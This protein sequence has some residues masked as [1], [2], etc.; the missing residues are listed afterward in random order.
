MVLFSVCSPHTRRR[1][2]NS[3]PARNLNRGTQG[4]NGVGKMA[5]LDGN[6]RNRP[7][8]YIIDALLAGVLLLA[9]YRL[10]YRAELPARLAES[11]AGFMIEAPILSPAGAAL[12]PGDLLVSIEDFPVGSYYQLE[13]ISNH[14][15]P[16]DT[17]QVEVRRSGALVTAPVIMHRGFP[18]S[19]VMISMA[20]AALYFFL[21]VFVLVRRRGSL[22]ARVF[23]GLMVTA[24]IMLT[25]SW[26]SLK[27]NPGWV[28]LMIQ[29]LDMAGNA[30][31]PA[32][33]LHF[34][35]VFPRRKWPSGSNL[36][37][38]PYGIGGALW[39]WLAV[40]FVRAAN[41]PNMAAF[42]LFEGAFLMTRW[43]LAIALIVMVGNLI[44]SFVTARE[45]QERRKLLWIGLGAVL[46]PLS[47]V[48]LW[49]IPQLVISRPLIGV[50]LSLILLG[51][52]PITFAIAIIRHHVLDIFVLFNRS[53][54][55]TILLAI[56]FAVYAMVVGLVATLVQQFTVTSSLL[57]SALAAAIVMAILE[58]TRRTVMAFVDRTIFRTAYHYREAQKRFTERLAGC[59]DTRQVAMVITAELD[60]LL[61]PTRVAVF[62]VVLNDGSVQLLDQRNADHLSGHRLPL[63]LKSSLPAIRQPLALAESLEYDAG[64]GQPPEEAFR[65]MGVAL[66]VSML[67]EERQRLGII[68]IGAKKSGAK[69]TRA[70]VDLLSAFAGQAVIAI[71]RILLH[72]RLV[73]ERAETRRLEDLN[74]IKSYFVSSV[75]HDLKTPLTSIRLF[76][77]LMGGGHLAPEKI[78]EYCRIIEGE[79]DRLTRLIN[80]V[81]DFA[82]IEKGI[83]EYKFAEIE[84]NRLVEHVMHTMA[85]QFEMNGF[86]VQQELAQDELVLRAD[87]DAVTEVL[88]NLLAN[89][90]KYVAET[91][92]IRVT[93]Y[94]RDRHVCVQVADKGIGIPADRQANIFDPFYRAVTTPSGSPPGT[95]L[96]LSVVK[97]VM[98]AHRGHIDLESEPGKGSVFVLNFPVLGSG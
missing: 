90:L 33:A 44:H 7:Y 25:T 88:V 38:V 58:P 30:F 21:A 82:K 80:N 20:V 8:I 95:G 75:S 50:N 84:L 71:D 78:G 61:A 55:L 89:S 19:T 96:G 32:L 29:I 27:M 6:P 17:V 22:E 1:T 52:V 5:F 43:L 46:G 68:L 18:P 98:E 31:I 83:K 97:H 54:A 86:T 47:Y 53:T 73:L 76:A 12:A 93:T 57:A 4:A 39:L 77:E 48:L 92:Q 14:Y 91:K 87:A 94:S 72:Q 11:P 69:F 59:V 60:N 56:M 28:G 45:E 65:Q 79:S 15:L 51:A 41:P 23:H 42:R 81:L 66:A 16:G 49:V 9:V 10:Q 2:D 70:D 63:D 37:W 34:S 24:A 26:A 40:T 67:S 74:K 3:E 13:F 64:A 62:G 36:I 85:Y 35:F